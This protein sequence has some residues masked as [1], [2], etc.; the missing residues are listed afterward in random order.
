[1]TR[2]AVVVTE[3]YA[4]TMEGPRNVCVTSPSG[5]RCIDVASRPRNGATVW[6]AVFRSPQQG[7]WLTGPREA[8]LGV[9][10][11]RMKRGAGPGVTNVGGGLAGSGDRLWA[12]ARI[13]NSTGAARRYYAEFRGYASKSVPSGLVTRVFR[14]GA[15]RCIRPSMIEVPDWTGRNYRTSRSFVTVLVRDTANGRATVRTGRLWG[16]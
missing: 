12:S 16:A 7:F 4:A 9:W 1:M 10:A 11:G 3:S 6:T 14:V 15:H 13:C 8:P 2:S 5:R